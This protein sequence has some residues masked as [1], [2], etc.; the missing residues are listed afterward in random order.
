[1]GIWHYCS[2][3]IERVGV[4]TLIADLA[5]KIDSLPGPILIMGASG[6]IG[7]SLFRCISEGRDDVYGTSSKVSPW[8]LSGF[9]NSRVRILDLLVESEVEKL[10]ESL[11]PKTIFN[12]VAYGAYPFQKN[13]DLIYHTNFFLVKTLLE[14]LDKMEIGSFINSGTSS[15][16][17]RQ[18]MAPLESAAL[19]PNSHYAVSKAA[20]SAA[21]YFMGTEENIPCANLRLYSVYGPLEDPSRLIPQLVINASK[22]DL[23]PFVDPSI[24]RDFIFVDDA[25]EAFL[26][27]ANKLT[28]KHYGHS[29]NVGTGKETTIGEMSELAKR[30]F[31][32]ASEPS[33]T[34]RN[35][36]WDIS[37]WYANTEKT[38]DILEWGYKTDLGDGLGKT[39]TWYN[40]LTETQKMSYLGASKSNPEFDSKYSV[41]VIVAC[42]KDSEAIPILYRRLTDCFAGLNIE[43]EIIFVNDGSP[44]NTEAIVLEISKS[45]HRVLGIN[46]SRNFG[47]QAAFRSGMEIAN[48]NAVVVMDGDLQDPPELIKDFVVKW[49]DGADVVYGRR[50]KRVAPWYMQMSYKIFYRLFSR[51]AY[52]KIPHDAGDFSLLDN[53]VVQHLLQF[54]E[55]DMFLR[56]LRAYVGFHQV[57]V[58]YVRPE[59]KFGRSTN[60]FFRNLDWAKKGL[61]SFS[62]APLNLLARFSY[63]LFLIAMVGGLYQVLSIIFFPES[64]PRGITTLILVNLVFGAVIVLA[65]GLVGEY[66]A[67]I[68]D[69]VKRRPRFIRHSI[70]KNG[71]NTKL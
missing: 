4:L 41:S 34:M 61:F 50:V 36:E 7:A 49:R 3:G 53:R 22:G 60:N 30:I 62:Y 71:I 29:F 44:D 12:C 45:D 14:K 51:F 56:G 24:S 6:F 54:P 26:D 66:V 58:D 2:T 57:G 70:I 64:A 69:E 10:L 39:L 52:I 1:V 11:K 35:R 23:P 20:A 68:F 65:I 8:R 43:Y 5:A 16:Y 46:H 19:T 40:Q 13:Q 42:Y 15:E 31:N 47:S 55:H 21:I 28:P 67:R 27:A 17:G 38:G 32:I 59:R 48:K 63:I 25:I 37:G 33:F 9:D 18:G